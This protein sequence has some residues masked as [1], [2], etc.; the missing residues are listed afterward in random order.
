MTNQKKL[1]SGYFFVACLFLVIGTLTYFSLKQIQNQLLYIGKNTVPSILALEKIN[2]AQSDILEVEKSLLTL[3]DT[4]KEQR[5]KD[6]IILKNA[7]DDAY[8]GWKI[9]EPIERDASEN[10]LWDN[11]IVCWNTWKKSHETV[12]RLLHS[13][14]TAEALLLSKGVSRLNYTRA[15]DAM[16]ALIDFNERQVVSSAKDALHSII[17]KTALLAGLSLFGFILTA[18]IGSLLY[19]YLPTEAGKFDVAILKNKIKATY[20]DSM[21]T[22]SYHINIDSTFDEYNTLSKSKSELVHTAAD[23][24]YYI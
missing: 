11:F 16:N 22:H 10:K 18:M 3:N 15:D 9:Y 2:A 17:P 21:I 4:D 14:H 20:D 24:E 1:L 7:W 8:A 6:M 23:L 12:L 13:G 5:Q 19:I